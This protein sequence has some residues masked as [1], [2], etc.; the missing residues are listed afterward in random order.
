MEPNGWV[1]RAST[2]GAVAVAGGLIGWVI[3]LDVDW[4]AAASSR[5][6]PPAPG[7]CIGTA[8]VV[9][10]AFGLAFTISACWVILA[11]ARIR[12]LM[13]SVPAAI[14]LVIVATLLFAQ[15]VH[16]VHLHPAW[17]FSLVTAIALA[18]PALI[19]TALAQR[20]PSRAG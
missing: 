11:V 12:P 7:L 20:S 4:S 15:H 8:A 1:Y 16:G 14:M 5:E 19:S 2:I 18:L 3:S 17:A 9:G 13:L 10:F 6:C